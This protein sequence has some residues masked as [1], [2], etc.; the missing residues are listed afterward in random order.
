[1]F[2]STGCGTWADPRV[3][4]G[5]FCHVCSKSD[6]DG[7]TN[8]ANFEPQG[9]GSSS[10]KSDDPKPYVPHDDAPDGEGSSGS[11]F[12]RL[13]VV[14][15]VVLLV[16]GVMQKKQATPMYLRPSPYA[17]IPPAQPGG[18]PAGPGVEL[19]SYRPVQT[20]PTAAMTQMV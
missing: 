20:S 2:L 4:E 6:S 9:H 7:G 13:T 19:P 5:P 14:A 3:E 15:I 8:T 16:G 18:G 12:V 1:M 11:W 10:K 17:Q